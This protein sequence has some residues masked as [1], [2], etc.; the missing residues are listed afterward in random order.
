LASPGKYKNL[1]FKINFVL[2]VYQFCILIES[3]HPKLGHPKLGPSAWVKDKEEV[4]KL[5]RCNKE[6]V[7]ITQRKVL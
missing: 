7:N 2:Y 6:V 1:Q 4:V 3:K 5:L